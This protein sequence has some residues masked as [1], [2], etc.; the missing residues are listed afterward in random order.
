MAQSNLTPSRKDAKKELIFAISASS[1]ET[2][3]RL[4]VRSFGCLA[5]LLLAVLI[6]C[7]TA[8]AQ[9]QVVSAGAFEFDVASV[10]P[11]Q[12]AT[13]GHF[14]DLVP[15]GVRVLAGDRFET[16]QAGLRTLVAFAYGFDRTFDRIQGG[17]SLLYETFAVVARGPSGSCAASSPDELQPVRHMVQRLLADRFNLQVHIEQEERRVLLLK[18]DSPTKLGPALRWV[19]DGCTE[20]TPTLPEDAPLPGSSQPRCMWA[21]A[22]DTLTGTGTLTATGTFR[23]FARNMSGSMQQ[24]VVDETGLAGAYLFAITFDP[25]TFLRLPP[26]VSRFR[27]PGQHADLPAFKTVL[28]SDLGLVLEE[29]T[30]QVPVLVITHIESLREN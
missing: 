25:E 20:A 16:S 12:L 30:R 13:G 5:V 21:P 24:E 8:D 7:S 11:V 10:R 27:R 29:A 19:A 3:S 18:R 6:L 4:R 9:Q 28:K 1:R 14:L 15:S 22:T 17:G 23:E 2:S 26:E